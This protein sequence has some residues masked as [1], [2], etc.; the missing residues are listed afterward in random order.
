MIASS[1]LFAGAMAFQRAPCLSDNEIEAALGAQIRAGAQTLNTSGLRNAPLCSAKT[2]PQ[3]IQEIRREAFPA[4]PAPARQNFA[5]E[6]EE[7]DE[8][9]PAPALSPLPA[10]A[11][12]RVLQVAPAPRARGIRSVRAQ[13]VSRRSPVARARSSASAYYRSCA[14]ARAAGAAPI[15][16]GQAGYSRHLDRDGDGIACE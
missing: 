5:D 7:I 4:P 16:R 11:V 1:I 8:P 13:A 9:A 3:R 12:D 2:L 15:R 14:V 6:R 10:V